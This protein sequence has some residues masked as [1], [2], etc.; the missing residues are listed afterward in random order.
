MNAVAEP[1][2]AQYAR[3]RP[4]G[5]RGAARSAALTALAAGAKLT[6]RMERDLARPRVQFI[7][8]HHVLA[9]EEAGFRRMLRELSR[10][11][12]FLSHSDAVERVHR[13]QID[14][15]YVSFSFDDGFADNARAARVLEEFGTVGCY[16]VCPGIVDET[17]PQKLSEFCAQRLDFP[18]VTPFLSWGDMETLISRGHEIGGHTMTHPS[19]GAITP[20]QVR[21]E[22]GQ[23]YEH[24]KRRLGKVLHFAWPKGRWINMSPVARDAVFAAGFISCASAVRG[25]HVVASGSDPASLCI[26]RD[27][28]LANWPTDHVQYLMIRNAQSASAADNEWPAE[29]PRRSG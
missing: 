2:F 22:V 25:C 11:H 15:P 1:T 20:E 13:G 18:I 19:L 5:L 7:Y 10:R 23:S 4:Q 29:Y 24:I 6:G 12:A 21:D 17:S 28:V 14:K 3:L 16:F 9:D 26:R 27:H 8:L